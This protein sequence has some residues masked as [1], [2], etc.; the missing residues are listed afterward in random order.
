MVR[1]G[2]V[3][4]AL[5]AI[6]NV[7]GF[8]PSTGFSSLTN[9]RSITHVPAVFEAKS[10]QENT[11]EM[12][13]EAGG[14]KRRWMKKLRQS[15]RNIAAA[16]LMGLSLRTNMQPADASILSADASKVSLTVK[17]DTGAYLDN[18]RARKVAAATAPVPVVSETEKAQSKSMVKPITAA[19]VVATGTGIAVALVPRKKEEEKEVKGAN[20]AEV[21]ANGETNGATNGEVMDKDVSSEKMQE[22]QTY[23]QDILKEQDV[24]V[25]KDD[26]PTED[27]K[28]EAETEEVKAETETVEIEAEIETDEE[29]AETETDEK[30]AETETEEV[31]AE[32]ET[33]APIEIA[34]EEPEPVKIVPVV[35]DAEVAQRK[36]E[37]E[38]KQ[39]ALLEARLKY[40]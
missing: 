11:E 25:S 26:S 18:M 34:K 40:M 39:R 6:S 19:A 10:K 12:E 22:A 31:K 5:L 21:E 8:A 30:K 33:E 9:T 4:V 20:G 35:L 1:S 15:K 2:V 32:T 24:V 27:V 36:K 38:A 17:V 29:K 13:P 7:D 23:V 28:V 14:K 16:A 3:V 37:D